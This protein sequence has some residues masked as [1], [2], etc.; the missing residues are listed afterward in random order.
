MSDDG[1]IFGG[2]NPHGLYVPMSDDEIEVISRL[3]ESDLLE[4]VIHGW[5]VCENPTIEFGDK[6][7]KIRLRIDFNINAEVFFF[8]MELRLREGG[9]TLFRKTEPTLVD[10]KPFI[11][12][13]G[14][15]LDMD[16]DISIDHM[17][18]ALVKEIKPGAFGLTSRRLDRD[19]KEPTIEGN[20]TLPTGHRGTL[21]IMEDAAAKMREGDVEKSTEAA[22][23]AG[24]EVKQTDKGPSAPEMD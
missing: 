11:A 21:H 16:W 17:D 14:G 24:L 9:K 8:D 2:K 12:I 19:T 13:A 20:L 22:K 23:K 3:V 10:G 18:P 5:G 7:V 6:R 1:N 4:V 15:Y